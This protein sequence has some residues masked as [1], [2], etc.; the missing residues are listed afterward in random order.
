MYVANLIQKPD[1]VEFSVWKYDVLVSGLYIFYQSTTWNI[2]IWLCSYHGGE[3]KGFCEAQSLT[4]GEWEKFF[5][6]TDWLDRNK[7]DRREIFRIR[8]KLENSG[9]ISK[10]NG[11]F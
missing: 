5:S 10:E 7:A 11:N 6:L 9:N 1:F 2:D 8:G 4:R 3:K